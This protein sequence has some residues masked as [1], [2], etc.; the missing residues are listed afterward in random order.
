MAM[1]SADITVLITLHQMLALSRAGALVQRYRC[2]RLLSTLAVGQ[3][4]AASKTVTER[5]TAR[6]LGSG[7]LD[8]FGTPAMVALMEEAA[9]ACVAPKLEA[10]QTTVG[11]KVDVVHLKCTPLGSTVRAEATLTGIKGKMLSFDVTAFDDLEKVGKGTHQRAVVVAEPFLA[12]CNG[13]I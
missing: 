4:G 2:S 13:K 11:T 12:A 1:T 3:T 8:V 5:I 10:G 6:T 7:S 9:C